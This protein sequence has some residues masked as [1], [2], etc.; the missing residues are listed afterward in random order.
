MTG[1]SLLVSKNGAH[2]PLAE[3]PSRMAQTNRAPAEDSSQAVGPSKKA[4]RSPRPVRRAPRRLLLSRGT[5]VRGL[6]QLDGNSRASDP[7]SP[8]TERYAQ[9]TRES[10]ATS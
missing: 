5:S 6:S 4:T 10:S 3:K 2:A 8:S 9:K 1:T 7:A